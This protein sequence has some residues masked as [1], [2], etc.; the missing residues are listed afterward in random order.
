MLILFWLMMYIGTYFSYS[1]NY[2]I[3]GVEY[4]LEC[5]KDCSKIDRYGD[6]TALQT[7]AVMGVEDIYDM[8]DKLTNSEAVITER[9]DYKNLT[10]KLT[11]VYKD[12]KLI[13]VYKTDE[14]N[15]IYYSADQRDTIVSY[16]DSKD[17]IVASIKAQEE[18]NKQTQNNPIDVKT[19]EEPPKQ[20]VSTKPKIDFYGFADWYQVNKNTI[21]NNCGNSDFTEQQTLDCLKDSY[22]YLLEP[23][24]FTK[25]NENDR[26][27][28]IS[29]IARIC[30]GVSKYGD[31]DTA[32]A[33]YKKWSVKE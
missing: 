29:A 33:L 23:E 28:L 9:L 25:A 10:T 31:V 1:R 6:S 11:L 14:A 8:P 4:R 5:S 24:L 21:M 22:K 26:S 15:V 16:K 13:K 19:E 18:T 7:L 27:N 17:A 20:E 12:N 3:D 2:K 32:E 30:G